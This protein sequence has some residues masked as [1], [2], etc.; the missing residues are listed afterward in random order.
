MM[1]E[2][3]IV[4]A[5]IAMSIELLPMVIKGYRTKSMDHV[6]W[7]MLINCEIGV[8]AWLC[9]AICIEEQPM[10]CLEAFALMVLTIAIYQK[11]KYTR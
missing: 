8:S 3:C 6:P 4:I 7:F 1:K 11:I 5:L 2:I 10:L 9:Y